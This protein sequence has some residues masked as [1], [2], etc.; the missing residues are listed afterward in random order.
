MPVETIENAYHDL[1]AAPACPAPSLV[2]EWDFTDERPQE[3]DDPPVC[4]F[5]PPYFQGELT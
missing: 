2:E 3:L 4:D 1:I 5:G